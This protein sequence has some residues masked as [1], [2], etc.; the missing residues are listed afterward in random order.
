MI[1]IFEFQITA[2]ALFIGTDCVPPYNTQFTAIIV[3][4]LVHEIL[5]IS[6]IMVPWFQTGRQKQASRF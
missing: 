3:A 1:L 2:I 5:A 6:E 4:D